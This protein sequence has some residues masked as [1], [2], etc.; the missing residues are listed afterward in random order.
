VNSINDT[1]IFVETTL[2]FSVAGNDLDT[3]NTLT[4]SKSSGPGSFVSIPGN[5]PVVGDFT[6]S[7]TLGDI[8]PHQL[9]FTADDGR[10]GIAAE[11]VTVEVVPTGI[12]LSVIGGEP[13]EFTEEIA[14]SFFVSLGGYDPG[15]L[16]FATDFT[17]HSGAPARYLASL[18]G[19]SI[20]IVS[21]F[22][23][24]DEFSNAQS[25]FAFRV[26]ASDSYS[27]DTL[28]LSLIVND[29]NRSPEIDVG[30]NYTVIV[31]HPLNFMVIGNDLDSDNILDLTL[32]SGPGSFPGASGPPPVSNIF[33]WT[34]TDA[35]V[36]GSPYT[37][38][39]AV[40][41]GRGGV[42]TANVTITVYP[43]GVPNISLVYSPS[44]F[45]EGLLDSV[46]FT[47]SDPEGDAMA[48]FGY[49]FMAPDS[50]FPGASFAVVNDTAYLR[51]TFDFVGDWSSSNEPF[52]LRLLGY[53]IIAD[54]DSAYLNVALEVINVN[55]KPELQVTGPN[56][57]EAG[58]NVALDLTATDFDT[59]DIIVLTASNL[60]IGSF[61]A[62]NG[63][64]TGDFTWSTSQGDIGSYSFRFY[65]DDGRG[66]SNSLDTVVWN[67]QVTP[68]DT[69]GPTQIGFEM[70]CPSAVPGS[71]VLVPVYLHTPDFYTG[72]FEVLIGW[73]PTV[74]TLL[75]AIP[76]ERIHFGSEYF[77]VHDED[78]GPGT[79]RMVWIADIND[80]VHTSP[81]F[82]G[83]DVIMWLNFHVSPGDYL[84]GI[85]VPI[86]FLIR[87]YSDNTI[88]DSTGYYLVWPLLTSGCVYI[89]DMSCCSGDPNMNCAPYEIADAVLVAQR[90]IEGYIVWQADDLIPNPDDCDRHYPGN[91]PLQE[92]SSDL[93]ANGF[94]DVADLVRF[95]NI[96]NGFIFPPK[97]D[98]VSGMVSMTMPDHIESVMAIRV[99][100]GYEIGGVL[101]KIDHAG[102][103]IGDPIPIDGMELIADDSDGILSILLYSLVGNRVPS[104]EQTLFTL[105]VTGNGMMTFA[106]VSVSDSYGR[107]LDVTTQSE[108]PLPTQ[109]SL[110]QNYPNPFNPTTGFELALAQPNDI[111][112][113]VYDITGRKIRTL[114]SARLE[115]GCHNIVWDGR[116]DNHGDVASGVY[117]ARITATGYVK[118][119]KM[120]LLR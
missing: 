64:R 22:D 35:D 26:T 109:T 27:A 90:L 101:V 39:F 1:T 31:D 42:D 18:D 2:E 86:D 7:P 81:M 85:L 10:G 84:S 82:P 105:P 8:G 99:R 45:Y 55:R 58:D 47:G 50:T 74:L 76:T 110:S 12:I 113:S 73:D 79:A 107:L 71:D 37:A 92:A 98:P 16:D 36:P 75:E 24:L 11:S 66:Q 19:N 87:H 117:F 59:D 115:A 68:P 15:S 29:N 13:P 103:E 100:S 20:R 21:T 40:S 54:Q 77:N 95:I 106:E 25:P 91:D 116:N 6:W 78:S 57:V 49:K 28:D 43:E 52:P 72:G 17:D 63:N 44:V 53:S 83:D 30:P 114:V 9:I 4:L 65:V 62:D 118:A 3:D 61:F 108:A 48:G 14:D 102:V 112:F 89:E 51:L 70:G 94:A 34:P 120:T 32:A 88:S 93:N 33:S 46:V 119:V 38:R 97:L 67:L 69:G 104:G 23:Y 96:I 56:T 60:P 80:G 5:P 111:D 41:D